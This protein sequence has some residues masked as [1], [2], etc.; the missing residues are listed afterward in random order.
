MINPALP[1]IAV[2][3]PAKLHHVMGHDP[4]ASIMIRERI[5]LGGAQFEMKRL[6]DAGTSRMPP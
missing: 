4:G 3:T 5:T 6:G 1:E 2:T